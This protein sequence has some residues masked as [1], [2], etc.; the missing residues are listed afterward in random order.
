[1]VQVPAAGREALSRE[2][3]RL[4]ALAA[5]AG[6]AH[7]PFQITWNTGRVA[8]RAAGQLNCLLTGGLRLLVE[9]FRRPVMTTDSILSQPGAPVSRGGQTART[10]LRIAA[11]PPPVL[12]DDPRVVVVSGCAPG[13]PVVVTARVEMPDATREARASFRAD[14]AGTVDTGRDTSLAGTYTGVDPFGLWWSGDPVAGPAGST[15]SPVSARVRVESGGRTAEAA[16]ARLWLAP[17]ATVTEVREPG[18]WGL[19]A[20][21]AGSGPFPA[22]IAF[23]GSGGGLGPAAAWAPVL[24]SHGIAALAIG[25][26]GAPGL[27]ETLVGIDVEV[28]ERAAEWLLR[29]P[30][31]APGPIAVMGQSRGS[32]LA[33]LAGALLE[34]IGP[35]V[36]FTPSGVCWAGIGAHGPVTA[37][38][39]R[40]RGDDIP[41]ADI[42]PAGTRLPAGAHVGP[43]I[44]MRPRFEA[45]LR[46]RDAVRAAEIPV[47]RVKGP[48][49]MVSGEADEM[50]PAT[51][52][53]DI[54]VHR[55][56]ARGFTHKL[57]H[58]RYPTAGHLCG[59][60]PG[61]PTVT[62]NRIPL[63]GLVY[64]LGGT[65]AG[66]AQ[67]RADS[68]PQVLQL[69]LNQ[70]GP[71]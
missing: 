4:Q 21:P 29:R 44:S 38:A 8:R 20:R 6:I 65:P 27:P 30:D 34:P 66:N 70:T 1:M 32:E 10:A 47:E 68:W 39:W 53:A 17:G 16:V 33:L 37:P 15:L 57:T 23:G 28:V 42:G 31:V 54:A 3:A 55:A 2:L 48:I 7:P 35:V 52:M 59:G 64:R 67:S 43:V 40:F 45:M 46:D 19:F 51:A 71:K 56:A 22:V 12:V 61:T 13:S 62:E 63:T 36:A 5:G 50:W 24:A 58:L 41:C 9:T 69:L 26:F 60:V 18:V 25:Y 49:L 11:P 14:A